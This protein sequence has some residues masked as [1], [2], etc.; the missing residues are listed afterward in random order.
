MKPIISIIIDTYNYGAYIENAINSALSQ[1]L[2]EDLREII[3]IDDGSIDD[4]SERVAA[5]GNK[6]V[7]HRKENGGQASAFN[8]GIS[9]ARG[10]YIAFLDADDY[11]YPTKLSKVLAIFKRDE[12]IGIVFNKFDMVDEGGKVI[13]RN[14]P[15]QLISGNIKHRVLMG[16]PSGSPSSGISIKKEIAQKI[17]VPEAP[18]RISADYFYLNI[19][20]L[21]TEVGV[22]ETSE[23]AYR[24]HNSNLYMKKADTE[25]AKMHINQ[26]SVI[27]DVA[28]KRGLSFFKGLHDLNYSPKAKTIHGRIGIFIEGVVWLLN[29]EG[30]LRLR[31][32]SLVKLMARFILPGQIYSRFQQGKEAL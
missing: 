10:D 6:I 23:H 22:I 19:I 1:T 17:S 8:V 28:E 13:N 25:R 14:M 4:T 29:A 31:G 27:L 16:Y 9:F 20:P 26:D 15:K 30:E 7:Y 24:I 21:I 2:L 5:F 18:F 3:V 32:R 11:F 12:N